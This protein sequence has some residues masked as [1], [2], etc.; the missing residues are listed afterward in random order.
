[1]KKFFGVILFSFLSIAGVF[2]Q[3]GGKLSV[4]TTFINQDFLNT[5]N[6]YTGWNIRLA[7]RLGSNVLFFAPE[8][9]YLN[10]T[11]LPNSSRNPFE[12]APRTHTLKIPVGLGLKFI[13]FY[14]NRIFFKGGA[15][16]SYVM[17]MDKNPELD[18]SVL[19]DSYFGYYGS[20]GYDFR[21]LTIDYRYEKSFTDQYFTIADSHFV[22]HSISLGVNF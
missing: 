13:T 22:F 17:K 18:F 7:G 19:N 2:A 12:K 8:L 16:Y 3:S 4:G 20:I 10:T 21:R 14:D 6:Q 9:N 11:A 15:M 5:S 1:M